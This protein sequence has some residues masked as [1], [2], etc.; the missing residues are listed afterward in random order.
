MIE[1]TVIQQKSSKLQV[2]RKT[3]P[4]RMHTGIAII[5]AGA[6]AKS[7]LDFFSNCP[8]TKLIAV[9]DPDKRIQNGIRNVYNLEKVTEDYRNFLSD[10]DIDVVVVCTPHHLH[11][12]VIKDALA[13]GKDV[14]CEKPLTV[15]VKQADDLID[16]AKERNKKLY[17]MLNM[18]FDK[19]HRKLKQL[20]LD[21]EIG[22]PFLARASYLGYEVE[23]L[24]D[25]CHWKGSKDRAGGGVLLDGGYHLI[26]L[27]NWLFGR[28][29]YVQAN[30]G[31]LVIDVANKGEDNVILIIEYAS[32]IVAELTVSF[33][34][35][36]Q[37][38]L[39]SPT[40]MLQ[41]DAFGT[42]GSVFSG[43]D[44][45]KMQEH[46][47]LVTHQGREPVKLS[48]ID[49]VDKCEHFLTCLKTSSPPIVSALNARNA[50]AVVEAAYESM[51]SGCKVE[52]RWR[53]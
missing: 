27:L 53:I 18:R 8:E 36:N 7:Y 1:K 11:Y 48:D 15:S 5:G 14:F 32:G 30:G 9:A 28:A 44:S 20:I 33:T 37:G 35:H 23:R 21:G 6:V 34:V 40:L 17:V 41:I 49:N 13:A 16:E 19:R 29:K 12:P 3:K 52:V 45:A 24:I 4:I 38:C 39:S 42:E 10:K 25:P 51:Q 26:D 2:L 22:R 31:Q 50:S 43:F 47:E 46:L